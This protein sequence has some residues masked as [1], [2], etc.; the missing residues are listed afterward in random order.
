MTRPNRI[1][2]TAVCTAVTAILELSLGE[3]YKYS[4]VTSVQQSRKCC[5]RLSSTVQPRERS[6]DTMH[7]KTCTWV[8]T[9]TSTSVRD[10]ITDC[11]LV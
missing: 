7:L 1:K 5:N 8:Q 9:Q 4:A 6:N 10:S 3:R 11:E 2:Q